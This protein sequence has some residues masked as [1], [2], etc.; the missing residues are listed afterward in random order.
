MQS[1]LKYKDYY[2]RNVKTAPFREKDYCFV[3]QPKADSQASRT[4]FKGNRLIGPFVI[5]NVL[6]NDITPNWTI[7]KL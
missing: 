5:Q 1:Y 2:E 7:K 6:P 3:L 4:P